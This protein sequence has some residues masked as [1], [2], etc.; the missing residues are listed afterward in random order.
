MD[1]Q[2]FGGYERNSET[3]SINY[4]SLGISWFSSENW[5]SWNPVHYSFQILSFNNQLWYLIELGLGCPGPST[6]QTIW[7]HGHP[8][9][10]EEADVCAQS[11][12]GEIRLEVV[13]KSCH[14]SGVGKFWRVPERGL[15][16]FFPITGLVLSQSLPVLITYKVSTL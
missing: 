3:C 12:L 15:D 8:L 13:Q 16:D 9:K 5:Y 7:T 1:R 6:F 10:R 11:Y 4:I 14:T 2:T